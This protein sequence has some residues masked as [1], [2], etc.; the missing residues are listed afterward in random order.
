MLEGDKY[1]GKTEA[2]KRE[3][4]GHKSNLKWGRREGLVK[5]AALE[6]SPDDGEGVT[7]GA[8]R[9]ETQRHLGKGI[10]QNEQTC[11][12]VAGAE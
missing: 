10:Q 1:H 9:A 7:H 8:S 5:E 3:R 2:G 12:R 4:N 6:Q 11:V